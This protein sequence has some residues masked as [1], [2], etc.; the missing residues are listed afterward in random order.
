[1]LN[2]HRDT[3][4]SLSELSDELDAEHV[5]EPVDT[6]WLRRSTGLLEQLRH[7]QWLYREGQTHRGRATMGILNATGCSSVWGSRACSRS[8][9]RAPQSM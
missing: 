6:E 1:M 7:L 9:P 2:S 8:R 4:L 5:A 3:D